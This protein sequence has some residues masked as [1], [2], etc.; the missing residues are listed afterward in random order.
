MNIRSPQLYKEHPDPT[1]V[2][3]SRRLRETLT[4]AVFTDQV[5]IF[6]DDFYL[7]S[8][9]REDRLDIC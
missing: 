1:E 4:Q 6:L 5:M 7:R 3:W 2:P 9:V 8:P